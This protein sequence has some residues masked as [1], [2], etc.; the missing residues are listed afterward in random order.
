MLGPAKASQL[1]P[2]DGFMDAVYAAGRR[3]GEREVCGRPSDVRS[4]HRQLQ[5]TRRRG[6]GA[7]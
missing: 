4:F 5:R 7:R 3:G 2:V 6:D 1:P